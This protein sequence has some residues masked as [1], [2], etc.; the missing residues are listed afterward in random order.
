MEATAQIG[1][2][3]Y[4]S[5]L[6][7]NKREIWITRICLAVTTFFFLGLLFSLAQHTHIAYAHNDVHTLIGIAI[8]TVSMLFVAYGN[9]L[10]QICLVGY[11]KRRAKH[12]PDPRD[13]LEEIYRKQAPSVSILVPSYKEEHAVIRQ[14][15]LSAALTE[16]PQKDIVLLI[17]DP[18]RAK[19]LE[20]MLSLEKTRLIPSEMQALFDAPAAHHIAAQQAFKARQREG[21]IHPGIELNRLSIAYE[22]AAL[23]LEKLATQFAAGRAEN[24]LPYAEKFFINSILLAPAKSHR[25]LAE[26]LRRKI[27]RPSSIDEA[28][29]ERHYARLAALFNVKFSSFERKKYTTLSHEANKAMNLNSYLSLMGKSWKE[30]EKKNGIA[31]C[32]CSPEEADFTIPYSDY[33]NTIDADSLMLSDYLLRLVHIIEQPENARVAVIQSP[34]SSFPGCPHALERVAGASIDVQFLNHQGYA[35]W[36]AASWVGANALLRRRALED[37]KETVVE[38]GNPVAIYIQDR[39]VIEDTESTIDLVAK[40]WKLYNYPERLTFSPTPPDFG[41]L[42]IQRRRWAN[43]GMIILPKL[44]AYAI[45][46]PKNLSLLKE[47]FMRFHYLSSSTTLCFFSLILF[48]YPFGSFAGTPWLPLLL[49]PPFLLYARDL[50]NAGYKPS[51]VLRIWSLLLMLLPIVMG[52]VLKQFEQMITSKKTPFC[53]TPK[54]PGRTAAPAFYY[55]VELMLLAGFSSLGLHSLLTHNWGQS[56]VFL[57]NAASMAYALVYFIGIKAMAEDIAAYAKMRW[58]EAFYHAE[59]IPLRLPTAFL[60]VR[61]RA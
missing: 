8:F 17:D 31:L 61:K 32:Q 38:N 45:R 26:Q 33:V 22:E 27:A 16:Y 41:A 18:Y 23:W 37:I 11:Y 53:R 3:E 25:M 20:D 50:K 2:R 44:I 10:Y 43:G 9:F 57:L 47:L 46:A 48:F 6:I 56:V 21:T 13:V 42:L 55:C 34:H 12:R 24:A 59:I 28:Y 35:Y 7:N 54:V 1:D 19:A 51:D 49:L 36:G 30:V 4:R 29:L 60:P 5:M 39:T 52:G 14:T 15:L 58:R 40:G